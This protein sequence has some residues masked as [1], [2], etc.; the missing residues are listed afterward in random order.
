M[1]ICWDN[2]KKAAATTGKQLH[3]SCFVLYVST[4]KSRYTILYKEGLIHHLLSYPGLLMTKLSTGRC[5]AQRC[6]R[7]F[8]ALKFHSF[9]WHIF[10]LHVGSS[11][12]YLLKKHMFHHSKAGWEARRCNV[13]GGSP[14]GGCRSAQSMLLPLWTE[15]E[16]L[17]PPRHRN[18]M[19]TFGTF[20]LIQTLII[21]DLRS[22]LQRNLET[23]LSNEKSIFNPLTTI[24]ML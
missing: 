16:S 1:N 12:C 5:S 9:S 22:L 11:Q 17:S 23:S 18:T 2:C 13:R 3:V 15:N 14:Q 6:I 10:Y 24:Q 21:L 19:A 4:R 7:R 20:R 8:S